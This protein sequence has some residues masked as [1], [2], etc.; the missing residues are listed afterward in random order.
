MAHG[1]GDLPVAALK[2]LYAG[3]SGALEILLEHRRY[4]VRL[5]RGQ[6]PKVKLLFVLNE[7]ARLGL[8]R[9][10]TLE[11]KR[12]LHKTHCSAC[13]DALEE[14]IDTHFVKP[15]CILQ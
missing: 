5:L 9:V 1:D 8:G 7:I 12:L 14:C 6:K 2:A 10:R 3:E 15:F 4:R 13:R 11:R